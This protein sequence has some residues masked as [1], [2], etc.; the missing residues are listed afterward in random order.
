MRIATIMARSG[1]Q[2]FPRKNY[3]AFSNDK[4]IVEITRD[5]CI[6]S[7]SFDKVVITSDDTYFEKYCNH[8]IV[9]FHHRPAHLATSTATTDEVMDCLFSD[10]E[11][12]SMM[13]VNSVSPLQTI[14]DIR[15]CADGL[16]LAD[17]VMAVNTLQ[18]HCDFDSTPLNYNP[19]G[20]FEPTQTLV[21]VKRH[22]YSCM[23]WNKKTYVDSR[24]SGYEGLFPGNL[25]LVEVSPFAG[26]LIKYKE[27]FE[28]YQKLAN[29][30]DVE[31]EKKNGKINISK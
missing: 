8:N 17:C 20:A 3:H 16:T 5:K 13:I 7:N 26:M 23:G 29:A 1:T 15:N 9:E 18:Q 30:L 21:P 12:N 10:Y 25:E 22:V 28:L 31:F 2:R 4:N 14:Q 27:D 24:N 19:L 11:C 6:K